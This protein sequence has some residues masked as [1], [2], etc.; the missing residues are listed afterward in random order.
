MANER[1][2]RIM[3]GMADQIKEEVVS[4]A[5]VTIMVRWPMSQALFLL[6]SDDEAASCL[7]ED[8]YSPKAAEI[9]YDTSAENNVGKKPN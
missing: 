1:V 6:V 7:L 5:M 3:A 9:R 2:T 4:G 8:A